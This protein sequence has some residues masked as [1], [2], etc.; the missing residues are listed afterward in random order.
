MMETI[1]EGAGGQIR[2]RNIGFELHAASGRIQLLEAYEFINVDIRLSEDGSKSSLRH[3]TGMVG[4]GCVTIC[5]LV[6]PN[7]VAPGCLPIKG[8]SEGS[9]PS[10]NF[11]VVES[12]KS[13]HF[14]NLRSGDSRRNR[15]C[16]PVQG[17]LNVLRVLQ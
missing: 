2:T 1:G 6:V 3:F 16:S 4:Y 8:E 10:H 15:R 7:L 17:S 11:P 9:A 12:C 14:R 5:F 13:S